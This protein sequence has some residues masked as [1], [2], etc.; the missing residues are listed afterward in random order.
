MQA[1]PSRAD[2]LSHLALNPSDA[3]EPDYEKSLMQDI[4]D[5][6]TAMDV[7]LR[8]LS[9]FYVNKGLNSDEQV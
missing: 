7:H 6:V 2:F 3:S 5:Y 8:L 4:E 9:D 1:I